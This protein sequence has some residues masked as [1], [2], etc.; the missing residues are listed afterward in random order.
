MSTQHRCPEHRMSAAWCCVVK[1]RERAL[2]QE[3]PGSTPGGA[4]ESGSR[5][6]AVFRL[7]AVGGH[8]SLVFGRW[9]QVVPLGPS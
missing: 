5:V 6:G 1:T 9:S 3:S 8:W 2:D 7:A 4:M